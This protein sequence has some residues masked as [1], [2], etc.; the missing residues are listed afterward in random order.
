MNEPR[1]PAELRYLTEILGVEATLALIER[2]GGTRLWVPRTYRAKSEFTAEFGEAA[3]RQLVRRFGG[4]RT[5]KVP[6]C[7]W[8]RARVYDARGLTYP[9]I[10]RKLGCSETT[11]WRYLAPTRVTPQL[12]LPLDAA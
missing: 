9:Q 10:A 4:E 3:A 5:L 1:P 12:S 7:K 11:V 2:R 6:L 8:W